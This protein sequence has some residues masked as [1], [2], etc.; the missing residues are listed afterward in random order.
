MKTRFKT[1]NLDFEDT[2]R[3][4]VISLKVEAVANAINQIEN[5]E[6]GSVFSVTE[7]VFNTSYSSFGS[8]DYG[9]SDREYH[10]AERGLVVT[11]YYHVKSRGS[12][13][14]VVG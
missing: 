10:Y 1:I 14:T 3:N 9:D 6:Q 11:I 12:Q 7:S 4:D 13:K 8:A 5:D 2:T